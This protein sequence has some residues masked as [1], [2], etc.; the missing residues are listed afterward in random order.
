MKAYLIVDLSIHDPQGFEPYIASIPAVIAGHGGKFIVSAAAPTP[1]EGD[2]SPER[3][4]IV[5][6]PARQNAEQFLKDPKF[7]ELARIRRR[8]TISK[9]VLVDGAD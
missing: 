5:E 1:V 9:L 2:W 6:F 8:T 3:M 4:V 7:Q